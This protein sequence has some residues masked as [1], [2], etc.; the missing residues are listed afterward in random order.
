MTTDARKNF[1][2]INNKRKNLLKTK[3]DLEIRYSKAE[4]KIVELEEE[5]KQIKENR[6]NMIA[7]NEDV[8]ALTQRLKD[9]DSEI[10]LNQDTIK[11]IGNKTWKMSSEIKSIIYETNIAFKKVTEEELEKLSKKYLN[12]GKKFAKI[13][14]EYAVL[15]YLGRMGDKF[16]HTVGEEIPKIPNIEDSEH[17]LFEYSFY[18]MREKYGKEIREKYNL[19]DYTPRYPY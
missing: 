4:K 12:A 5:K 16:W 19:P 10:D 17:P 1:E 7:N 3:D 9:I 2:E 11:G 13:L 6:P 15:Q 14:T 18:K 8:T